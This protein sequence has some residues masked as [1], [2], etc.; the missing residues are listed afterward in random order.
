M[1]MLQGG[2]ELMRH[3][4][5][6]STLEYLLVVVAALLAVLYGVKVVLQPKVKTNVDA[7]GAILDKANT[8]LSGI[9]Q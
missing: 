7:A 3:R 6:Q 4:R 8:E 5:G 2:H 1:K 9:A